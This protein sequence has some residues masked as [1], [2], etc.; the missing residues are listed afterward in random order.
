MIT[1]HVIL[2]NIKITYSNISRAPFTN[3]IYKIYY[4][5]KFVMGLCQSK[6]DVS[7]PSIEPTK[8]TFNQVEIDQGISVKTNG[9]YLYEIYFE[10]EIFDKAH[11]LILKLN[12]IDFIKSV[13]IQATMKTNSTI[14]KKLVSF[15]TT[16][17]ALYTDH[18]Q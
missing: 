6:E 13:R 16:N 4:F 11:G 5:W 9:K 7:N 18:R 15:V 3:I 10:H 2:T 8:E 12:L 14:N 17:S 1:T